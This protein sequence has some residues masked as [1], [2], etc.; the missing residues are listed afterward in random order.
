MLLYRQFQQRAEKMKNL[1]RYF[2]L[3]ALTCCLFLGSIATAANPATQEKPLLDQKVAISFVFV[4]QAQAGKLTHIKGKKY[5]LTI[6][7]KNIQSVLAL[8]GGRAHVAHRMKPSDYAKLVHRGAN[9]FDVDPPNA[10]ITVGTGAAHAYVI[11]KYKLLG[12]NIVYNLSLLDK[13]SVNPASGEVS[14]FI[15]TASYT[16]SC[17]SINPGT[18]FDSS[19]LTG[20][21][22]GDTGFMIYCGICVIAL[23]VDPD[24]TYCRTYTQ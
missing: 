10:G 8:A 2:T 13:G 15:D 9:S 21:C 24:S 19:N 23:S 3:S 5:Q 17:C 11:D 16:S 1:I 12:P 20:I 4:I 18:S 14:M 22:Y 6:P 7:L